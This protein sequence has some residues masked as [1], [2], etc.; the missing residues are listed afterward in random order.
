M[1]IIAILGFEVARLF[2]TRTQP[3]QPCSLLANA[4]GYPEV[5][6]VLLRIEHGNYM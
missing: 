6:N 3:T 4:D 1:S 5:R 2:N